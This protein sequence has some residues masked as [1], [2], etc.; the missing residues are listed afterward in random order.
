MADLNE[1]VS[2]LRPE[3]PGIAID[4]AF[5]RFRLPG[6]RASLNTGHIPSLWISHGDA[7]RVEAGPWSVT[8][9]AVYVAPHCLHVVDGRGQLFQGVSL[10]GF[11]WPADVEPRPVMALSPR[12]LNLF[13]DHLQRQDG[14]IAHELAA[15]LGFVPLRFSSPM[16]LLAERMVGDPMHRLSQT[17]ASI[18]TGMERTAMLKQFRRESGMSFRTFKTSAGVQ[19]ALRLMAVGRS[20][21]EAAMA[22]GFADLAH[23]S[24]HCRAA[25]GY[26]PR[27][28]LQYLDRALA[29]ARAG[30][31]RLAAADMPLITRQASAA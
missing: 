12:A 8:A 18:L 13:V 29:M 1:R 9:Q 11:R 7:L 27:Q 23:F 6:S 2:A 19:A 17:E 15:L 5:M 20:A 24:R 30:Q 14:S 25:T 21:S 31:T 26:S 3:Q 22:G 16:S 28:G 4:D 10:R